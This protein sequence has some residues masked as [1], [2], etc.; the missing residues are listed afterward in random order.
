MTEAEEPMRI[1]VTENGPYVV[2]GSVPL[3]VQ[4]IVADEDGNSVDWK[5]GE[6]LDTPTEYSL[7]RCGQSKNKPFCDGS[8]KTCAFMAAERAPV[9][10]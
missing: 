3:A 8:H 7:C 9:G 10:P 4:A 6:Q 5:Q 1:T 2:T